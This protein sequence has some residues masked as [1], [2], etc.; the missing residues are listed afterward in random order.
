MTC[1]SLSFVSSVQRVDVDRTGN[2]HG[3]ITTPT[4]FGSQTETRER[5]ILNSA[6]VNNGKQEN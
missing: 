5:N 3:R 1:S 4:Q 2:K 6:K